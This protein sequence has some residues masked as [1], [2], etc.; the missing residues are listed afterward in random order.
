MQ[1]KLERGFT[2]IELIAVTILLSILGVVA[3]SRL[4]NTGGY[5]SRAFFD[6]T[7]NA[8]RY[9]QKLAISTG[10]DVR[11]TIVN[12]GPTPGY[13]LNQ[14]VTNC[15][16]GVFTRPVLDPADRTRQYQNSLAGTSINQAAN[17]E[18]TPRSTVTG[19]G[20]DQSFTIDGRQFTVYQNSGLV[21]AQ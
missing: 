21:D 16:T 9:A 2:L 15:T 5:E 20:G 3:M 7:V 11:V 18:F 12:T 13:A 19:L 6:D 4:D 1:E 17:F 10:C 8:L 14:R